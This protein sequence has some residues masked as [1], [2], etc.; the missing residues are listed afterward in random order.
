MWKKIFITISITEYYKIINFIFLNKFKINFLRKIIPTLYR[1]NK[2][3]AFTREN[4]KKFYFNFTIS[5]SFLYLQ[6]ISE[7]YSPMKKLLKFA[8]FF[9]SLTLLLSACTDPETPDYREKYMGCYNFTIYRQTYRMID[10]ETTF[11]T[12]YHSG[13][14]NLYQPQDEVNNFFPSTTTSLNVDSAMTLYFLPETHITTQI[15]GSGNF[16]TKRNPTASHQIGS[17]DNNGNI[18]FVVDFWPSLSF[19]DTYTVT[20]YKVY[21]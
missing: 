17:I 18:N 16:I 9:L 21:P 1:N 13:V 7:K 6:K 15:D 12:L 5:N 10:N 19:H 20:G 8:T 4:L 3:R 2:F 14:F 11:D